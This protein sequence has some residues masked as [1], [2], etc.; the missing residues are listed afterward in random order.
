MGQ[1][2]DDEGLEVR[3]VTCP[4]IEWTRAI[5]EAL[6]LETGD[7]CH[8]PVCLCV[9]VYAS[10]YSRDHTVSISHGCL[11]GGPKVRVPLSSL[12]LHLSVY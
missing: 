2:A 9:H 5:S 4:W 3:S 10:V 11:S 12:A 6:W 1:G 7:D 8:C